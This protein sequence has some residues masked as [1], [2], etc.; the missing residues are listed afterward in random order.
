[1][2]NT[3]IGLICCMAMLDSCS[4][5]ALTGRRQLTAIPSSQMVMLGEES[6]KK[7]LQEQELSDNREYINQVNR[8]GS[9]I[10]DAVVKYLRQN[11]MEHRIE[12]FRWE[13][14]VIDSDA[15]NAWCL[16]GGKIG[17]Y[18]GIM[19]VCEDDNGVAAVMAHEIAHAIA[20]HGNERLSQQ[21]ALQLGGMALSVAL[22]KE[23][24]TTQQLAMLAFGIGSKVGVMLPYSR[25][26][27]KEADE[28]G[29]Y[30]M[31][32][33]GYDPRGAPE[34]WSRL[35][36]YSQN[37]LPEFLSTHPHPASRIRILKK[38][39]PRALD[40]YQN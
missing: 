20:R 17:F 5:V 25:V 30:L 4:S 11:E 22:E 40:Y 6:Y 33:A 26:H 21:L 13:Y 34:F 12:T 36:Q 16:P 9:M 19:P 38:H 18:E 28:M 32:M 7:V 14:S 2:K 15:L 39:M 31:A 37:P 23:K 24:E 1:M 29:L 10:S 8:V 35:Q 3:L 27:E